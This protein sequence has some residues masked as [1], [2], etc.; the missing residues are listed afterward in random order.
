LLRLLTDGNFHSAETL[1]RQLG[2]SLAGLH[3]A[4]HHTADYGLTLYHDNIHGYRLTNPPQ[5]L[6]AARIN[7]HLDTSRNPFHLD[8]L[9]NIPSSN[10]LLLQRATQ[11]APSGTVIAAEWQSG[12]RGRLG[13]AWYAGLGNALTFSLL[14]R[15]DGG[16]A[17]LSGLSLAAGV[18]VMRVLNDLG[19]TGASLKWPNDV[20]TTRGKLAG[21]L[22]EAQG[23][24]QND[25]AA[26]IG[27]GLNLARVSATENKV[28]QPMAALADLLQSVPE[29]ND[30]LAMLLRALH[31]ILQ[32]FDRGGFAA[33]REE[34]E[35][36]HGSQNQ[37]V[38]LTMPDGGIISGIARG[39]TEEGALLLETAE[40][41][42]HFHA[43]E[44]S[45]RARS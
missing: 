29:R 31:D 42:R 23:G 8:I 10:T 35:R 15:F 36:Y 7:H 11:G 6:D 26:V 32:E 9:D 45:L 19:A 37:P 25:V 3:D 40:G 18:A 13:R 41:V 39:V 34:W 28:N 4:L 20:M 43:G 2:I 24:M 33:L 30:L 12:G 1:S 44:I 21:I 14:W 17:R 38:C 16:L 5:W 22:V 27:I